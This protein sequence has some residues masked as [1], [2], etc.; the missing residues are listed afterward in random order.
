MSAV[1]EAVS[2][3]LP[4]TVS[5]TQWNPPP[6]FS[7]GKYGACVG[8]PL[9]LDMEWGSEPASSLPGVDLGQTASS[10]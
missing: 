3:L 8:G 10:G 9:A 1:F 4:D 5:L 6:P 7:E 2:A